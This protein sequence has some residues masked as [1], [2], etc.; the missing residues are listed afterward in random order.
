MK[1][2]VGCFGRDDCIE[3]TTEKALLAS[4][5]ITVAIFNDSSNQT[6]W[7]PLFELI[8]INI[9]LKRFVPG[10]K[11]KKIS[12][13]AL[14]LLSK[15]KILVINAFRRFGEINIWFTVLSVMCRSAFTASKISSLRN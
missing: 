9:N 8:H 1:N 14:E 7:K 11:H 4:H 5:F 15:K 12:R 3:F 13:W 6:R 2:N 10:K